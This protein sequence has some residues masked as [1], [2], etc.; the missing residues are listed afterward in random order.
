[1]SELFGFLNSLD[2]HSVIVGVGNILRGDDGF[3]PRFVE[4]LRDKTAALLLDAG[5]VPEDVLGS[6]VEAKPEKLL[7]ADAMALGGK[8]GDAALLTPDQ[9]GVRV[10]VSTHTL[11]LV[12]SIK[13]LRERL[14]ETDIRILGVQPRSIGFGEAIGPEVTR[15]IETLAAIAARTA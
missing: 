5:E 15:T 10:P 4:A 3:G 6:A 8:P 9:L 11:P 2:Q 14:P 1:M 7:I 12:M 13:Y